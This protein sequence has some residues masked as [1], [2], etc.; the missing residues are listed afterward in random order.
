MTKIDKLIDIKNEDNLLD[1]EQPLR[2]DEKQRILQMTMNKLPDKKQTGFSKKKLIISILAATMMIGTV[3]LA[4]DNLS[5]SKN[6]PLSNYLSINKDNKSLDGAGVYLNKSVINNNLKLTVKHTLGDKH[7][8]YLL[9]DVE[10]PNTIVIPENSRFNEMDINFENPSPAGWN[11]SDLDDE[12]P[13]DNKQSYII[14]YSTEGKLNGS[15]ISL[16]F[17]D[18]GYYSN[19][20]DEFITLVKGDWNVSW[21]LNYIDISKEISVNKFVFNKENKYFIKNINIS[22]LSISANII[23]RNNG[24][25]MIKEVTFNDGTIYTDK[26]FSSMHSSSSFLNIFTSIEFGK[27]IDVNRLESININ[28]KVINISK[29]NAN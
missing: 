12:N 4:S 29:D 23:G 11:I 13:N 18:F 2:Y 25:F 24:S 10:T 14:A 19:E 9:I 8:L 3:A 16:N 22:P 6:N 27:V 28:N 7:N 1:N 26:D 17:K 20:S 15:D 5:I 21:Q